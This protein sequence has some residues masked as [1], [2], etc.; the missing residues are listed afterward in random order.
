MAGPSKKIHGVMRCYKNYC[1]RINIVIFLT[2]NIAV[3]V[4]V[5][6]NFVMSRTEC[7]L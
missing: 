1:K 4:Y 7:Q 3:T 6:E 5:C 2:V